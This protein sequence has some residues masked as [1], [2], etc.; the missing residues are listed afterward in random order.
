MPIKVSRTGLGISN[1]FFAD[2]CLLFVKAKSSQVRLVIQVLDSFYLASGL[3]INLE[4]S[5]FMDSKNVHISTVEKFSGIMTICSTTNF[6]KYLGF[7]LLQGRVKKDN[8]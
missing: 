8:F 3:K 6:G 7:P 4:K 5:S 2:D 1:L